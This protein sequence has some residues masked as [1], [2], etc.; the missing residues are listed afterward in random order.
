ML[1]LDAYPPQTDHC[2]HDGAIAET[3]KW[4]HD[5]DTSQKEPKIPANPTT[6]QVF[7]VEKKCDLGLSW[8]WLIAGPKVVLTHG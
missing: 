5:I 3:Q 7:G 6:T 8:V 1:I 2:G 4:R